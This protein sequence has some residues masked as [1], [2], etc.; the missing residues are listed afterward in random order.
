MQIALLTAVAISS[1]QF[2][3]KSKNAE[4]KQS[5][6]KVISSFNQI[7]RPDYNK[8]VKHQRKLMLK[9]LLKNIGAKVGLRS[10]AGAGC[11]PLL[12]PRP[13]HPRHAP[14][15]RPALHSTCTICTVCTICIICTI[16]TAC[17]LYSLKCARSQTCVLCI[18]VMKSPKHRYEVLP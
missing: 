7:L 13:W 14:P 17:S 18:S 10:C 2:L 12:L 9:H 4:F 8:K 11:P 16:C 6:K 3:V 5:W 1:S 15:R